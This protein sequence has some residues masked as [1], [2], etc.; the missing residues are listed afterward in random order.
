MLRLAL[1]LTL[2]DLALVLDAPWIRKLRW[3]MG[4]AVHRNG[5]DS[6]PAVFDFRVQDVLKG[7][8]YL[9]WSTAR[10]LILHEMVSILV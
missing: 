2:T 3:T 9:G 5:E 6:T 4:L 7:V 1:N 8:R 10:L